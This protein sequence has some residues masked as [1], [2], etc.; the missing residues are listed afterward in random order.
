MVHQ[1]SGTTP[2]GPPVGSWLDRNGCSQ[3]ITTLYFASTSSVDEALLNGA[4]FAYPN[5]NTDPVPPS[6]I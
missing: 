4:I 5:T 6:S 3:F 2:S 1:T